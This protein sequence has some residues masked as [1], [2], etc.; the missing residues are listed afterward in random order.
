MAA[1]SQPSAVSYR[2]KAMQNRENQKKLFDLSHLYYNSTE[3]IIQ[4]YFK[5]NFQLHV[6]PQDY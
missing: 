6:Y 4:I 5:L 2:G 3:E 1:G